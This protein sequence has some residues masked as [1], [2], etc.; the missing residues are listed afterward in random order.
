MGEAS[1]AAVV[2]Y[3]AEPGCVGARGEERCVQ[4]R[5]A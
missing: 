2:E 5:A 3:D 1:V 4:R